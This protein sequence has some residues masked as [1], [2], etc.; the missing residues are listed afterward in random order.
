MKNQI[1]AL[2]QN[3]QEALHDLYYW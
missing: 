3:D 2:L 1:K